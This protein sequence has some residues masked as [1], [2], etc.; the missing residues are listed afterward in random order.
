MEINHYPRWLSLKSA[1][2]YSGIGQRHLIRLA[3]TG[4]IRGGQQA[5][6]GKSPWFFD[7]LSIDR[8]MESMITG[9]DVER[10]VDHI[11]NLLRRG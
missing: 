5:D 2:H 10:R 8:Y 11:M 3:G 1:A 4:K 6:N 7:R 9:V